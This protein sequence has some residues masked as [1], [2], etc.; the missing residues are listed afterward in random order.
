MS[1]S[2]PVSRSRKVLDAWATGV[3]L[4]WLIFS[5]PV[6]APASETRDADMN[7]APFTVDA[8][9]LSRHDVVFQQP[10][11]LEA[12][13]FPLGNGDMGG[14]IWTRT[15]GVEF[16]INKNDVWSIRESEKDE[17]RTRTGPD[18]A[19]APSGSS[20]KTGHEGGTMAVPRHC[21]RVRV[22]FGIP[23][24][25]WIHHMNDFEGRFSLAKGEALFRAD[26]GYSKTRISSWLSQDMNVWVVE[27]DNAFEEELIEGGHSMASVTLE[28]LGSRA[29]AGWYSGNFTRNPKAGIGDTQTSIVGRDLVI[30]ENGEGMDFA[31]A[32]RVLG[33][34]G[35]RLRRNNHRAEALVKESKFAVLVSVVTRAE[36]TDP[37]AEAR[38]LLDRAEREGVEGMKAKKDAWFA[39]FW[40]NSFLKLGDDYL[41][42]IY[43]LRRYLM[44]IGSRGTYPVVFNG[45]L[46]RWNRDVI[47]WMT[48]HHWNMQQQYWG[49][50]AAN[51]CDE[52]LP[53][54]QTYFGMM[55]GMADLATTLGDVPKESDAILLAE[56]HN[57]DGVMVDPFRRD[58]RFNYTPAAQVASLFFEYFEY[59]GDKEFLATK[60]YP[61]MKKAANFYL[62]KLT[63]DADK[64]V[65][66]FKGSVY[67]DGGGRGPALNPL[68]DRNCIEALFKSCIRAATIL[69]T[70]SDL[71]S[72]WNHVLDH[73]WERRFIQVNGID[74]EVLAACDEEGKYAP[75]DWVVGGSTAFPAGLIGIDDA[76]TPLGKATMNLIRSLKGSMYSHHPVPIISARMGDGD[77]ALKLIRDGISEMQYFPQ[78]LFFNCRGYPSDLY[79]LKSQVNLLGG[80]GHPHVKWRDFY[81][82]GMETI[83]LCATA[84]Q[85]MMLQSNE[86]KIRVFPAIPSEW[87]DVPLAFKLLAR[88]GFLVASE[89]QK[90]DIAQVGIKS[91]LGGTC[92]LQPPWPGQPVTVADGATGAAVETRVEA[93]DVITFASEPGREYVVRRKDSSAA[94]M[95]TVYSSEPNQEPKTLNGK[96]TLGLGQG[97]FTER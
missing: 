22:D 75:T 77:E 33:R 11:Q 16:Q 52:M 29:F 63:W 78:G 3:S 87:R 34:G 47:N 41:E 76:D 93:D 54:L 59:T 1:R 42:N 26:T 7:S 20:A 30:E 88:G 92:R 49:L 91:L 55:P 62:S 27:C 86:D 39:S 79:N 70:D 28:R 44:A 61:F 32:C 66:S 18:R 57:F 48:P 19:L 25:S 40:S 89:R 36:A 37:K 43:C 9:Y 90:G 71:I 80:P 85:D 83:S 6:T 17:Q 10:M 60:G 21:A 53:Y 24:F 56:M 68:S 2:S 64:K 35:E 46:W 65:F 82:C 58:M 51:D 38:H 97:F 12:E 23:V 5:L 69:D 67:E 4:L 96:R 50:C 73:L 81:Q 95:K 45:G 84:M 8:S 13:G 31:V 94:T 15:E 14:L 74:G 72:K